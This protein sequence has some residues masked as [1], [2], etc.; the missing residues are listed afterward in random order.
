MNG[1]LTGRRGKGWLSAG[2]LAVALAAPAAAQETVGR[3]EGDDIAVK[4]QVS[5]VRAGARKSAEL[6]SG[7]EVTV[8][9]G[10]ARLTLADGSEVDICGPAQFS[11]LRSGADITLALNFGRLHSRLSAAL[12][13]VIYTPQVVAT[14]LSI[15][16]QPRDIV[17][18]LDAAGAMCANTPR[19]ALRLEQQL[20]G[21]HIVIP[22]AAEVALAEGEIEAV[23]DA[24]G[25]CRCDVVLVEDKPAGE[26]AHVAMTSTRSEARK[27]KEEKAEPPAAE[28]PSWTVVM[29]PLTFDAGAPQPPPPSPEMALLIREVRLQPGVVFHGRVET[30]AESKTPSQ[31]TGS[32]K[33]AP[34]AGE[35][36]EGFFGKLGGF[37]RRV[38]GGKPKSGG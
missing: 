1:H 26:P 25:A 14:P 4:G 6:A 13:L 22:Q 3:I 11:V 28:T 9:A 10:Q 21:G 37:F 17:I 30:R 8:R 32:Q 18:G 34:Q 38:F 23:R 24:P 20:T 5:L 16:G 19:G 7:S 12:P 2:C 36:K 31:G 27:E 29:P 35:K 33:A 15:Q